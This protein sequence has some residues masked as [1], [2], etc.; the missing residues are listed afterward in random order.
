[1]SVGDETKIYLEVLITVKVE[2]NEMNSKLKMKATVYGSKDERFVNRVNRFLNRNFANHYVEN[3][4]DP[5]TE[6]IV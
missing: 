5:L 6:R 3:S 2:Y 1:M 4:Y